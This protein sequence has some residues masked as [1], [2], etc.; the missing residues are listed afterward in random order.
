MAFMAFMA[1]LSCFL[2]ELLLPAVADG[3]G[4]FHINLYIILNIL[5]LKAIP[6]RRWSLLLE[7]R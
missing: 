4:G 1:L 7:R 2:A 5:N 6:K 3:N